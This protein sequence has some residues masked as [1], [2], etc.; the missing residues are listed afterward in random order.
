MLLND[1]TQKIIG[2]AIEVHRHLGPGLLESTYEACFF[3]EMKKAGLNVINQVPLPLRYKELSIE[4]GY[5]LD[6]F[7]EG[8]VIV[9]VKSVEDLHPKHIAQVLTYLKL[10]NAD[11]GLLINF[12]EL[13]LK[14]GIKRLIPKDNNL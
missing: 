7:V 10:T 11:V 4:A 5:R 9:E 14:D 6:F 13:R 12:N 8:C 3:Y 1:I 2:C